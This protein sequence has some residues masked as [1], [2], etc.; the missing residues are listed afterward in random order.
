[1]VQ[2]EEGFLKRLL[3]DVLGVLSN[4]DAAQRHGK[5]LSLVTGRRSKLQTPGHLRF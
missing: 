2:V 4:A 3:H 1:L 5:N